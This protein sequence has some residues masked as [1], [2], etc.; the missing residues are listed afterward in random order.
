MCPFDPLH[1]TECQQI[2]VQICKPKMC[3]FDPFW[4][5]APDGMLTDI[6]I[7]L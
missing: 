6:C 5:I 3:P 4:S 1:P 2:F 7:N